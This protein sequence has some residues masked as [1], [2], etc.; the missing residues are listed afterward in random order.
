MKKEHIKI[1]F[2]TYTLNIFTSTIRG[3][4]R[5]QNKW[6]LNITNQYGAPV[7]HTSVDEELAQF[8]ESKTEIPT[9]TLLAEYGKTQLL[10]LSRRTRTV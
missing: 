10:N 4:G 2:D 8:V 9:K 7:M 5:Q 6:E 1:G 3:S